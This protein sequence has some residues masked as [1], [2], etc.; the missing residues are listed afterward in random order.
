M[1][2]FGVVWL[3]QMGSAVG[4]RM[5]HFALVLW[6]WNLTEQ[7]T[8]IALL[9]FFTQVPRLLI[10][11]LAGVMVDYWNRKRLMMV[12]DAVA[13]VSTLVIL[14]LH[15]DGNLTLGHLYG[16]G[17][18]NAAFSQIQQLAYTTSM[19]LMVP[20][21]HYSRAMSLN[22]LSGYGAGIVAPA[23]AGTLYAVIGLA[24]I[25]LIDLATFAIAMATVMAIT[26]PQP[27]GAAG[28]LRV[29]SL[30]QDMGAGFRY[31]G[32]RPG[33]LAVLVTAALFQFAHDIS[34]A[35]HAPMVLART[36]NNAQVL[37]LVAA[38]SGIGGVV[39]ALTVTAWGGPKRRIHGVLLGMVGAG[40][41]KIGFSLGRLPVVWVPMQLLSSLNFPVIG[42]SGNAIWLSQVSPERQGRVFA[43]SLVIKGIIP[44]LGRL[45]AGPLADTVLEP[46]MMPGGRLAPLLGR[47]FGTGAGA[48][49]A[50]LY[51]SSAIAMVLI[52]L[53][54]YLCRPLRQVEA[55]R[56][57]P[58]LHHP[59]SSS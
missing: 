14:G 7:A 55:T 33:M 38:A 3:G 10:T 2:T 5:T 28:P 32:D 52:G 13:G 58:T 47:V 8:A 46:A 22:F 26:I 48:G 9:G 51:S 40:L 43:V 54:G 39:G 29:S 31:I 16:A 44:P 21:R 36:G 25:L 35:I 15:L 12:G 53:G 1:G 18:I 6:V 56:P 11:P 50:V 17:A 19:T 23:L 49:M 34:N 27:P 59:G 45:I 4:S 24:G 37:A 42:S 41:S 57:E 30:L 20:E